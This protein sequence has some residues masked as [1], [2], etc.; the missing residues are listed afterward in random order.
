MLI[1]VVIYLLRTKRN[2]KFVFYCIPHEVLL[3][4]SIFLTQFT[5]KTDKNIYI[6]NGYCG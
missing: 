1:I 6:Y 3:L 4:V 2:I 5:A